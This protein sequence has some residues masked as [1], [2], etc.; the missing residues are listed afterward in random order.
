MKGSPR[1]LWSWRAPSRQIHGQGTLQSKFT[2]ERENVQRETKPQV[3]KWRL[4]YTQLPP[5]WEVPKK[6]KSRGTLRGGRDCYDPVEGDIYTLGGDKINTYNRYSP[7]RNYND[8]MKEALHTLKR[9]PDSSPTQK[10]KKPRTVYFDDYEEFFKKNSVD[11]MNYLFD[12]SF[13]YDVY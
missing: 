2:Q 7:L 5:P 1:D 10:R 9:P 8:G 4:I 13:L 12:D 3:K 6:R 11:F